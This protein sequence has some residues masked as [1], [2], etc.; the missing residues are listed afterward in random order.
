MEGDPML[1]TGI[2]LP[3]KWQGARGLAAGEVR[4]V[5]PPRVLQGCHHL[6]KTQGLRV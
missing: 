6:L 2:P 1:S 5:T 4:K 3:K